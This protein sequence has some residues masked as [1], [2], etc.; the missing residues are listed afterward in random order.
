MY[1]LEFSMATRDQDVPWRDAVV[2]QPPI[3]RN[4]KLAESPSFGQTI[5][6]YAP[7]CP[8]ARDYEALAAHIASKR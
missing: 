3:R 1:F 8:G 4:I 6:D 5:F 7:Y 2:F